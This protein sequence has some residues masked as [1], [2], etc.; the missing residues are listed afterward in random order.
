MINAT[1]ADLIFSWVCLGIV[2]LR[3]SRVCSVE[4]MLFEERVDR[5]FF[6]CSL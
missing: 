1:S 4:G 3:P 6:L 5:R 2:V